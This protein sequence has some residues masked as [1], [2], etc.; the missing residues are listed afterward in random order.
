MQDLHWYSQ[1]YGYFFGYG[2]GDL[3]SSQMTAKISKDL[4]N[5]KVSLEGGK[6]T[7]IRKWLETNVHQRG[8]T[9]DCLD[10]VKSITGE[11]LSPKYHIE[12]LKEKFS[13]LYQI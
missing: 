2:I 13:P 7:P 6:F 9:L 4:P 1:Y 10:M 8:G 11:D 5:W 12:Y 3:I